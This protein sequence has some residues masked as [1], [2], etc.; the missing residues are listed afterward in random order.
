MG[1]FS[2]CLSLSLQT[3]ALHS[4]LIRILVKDTIVRH[5]NLETNPLKRQTRRKRQ[6]DKQTRQSDLEWSVP[7]REI[8]QRIP[9]L[10]FL[11]L[12]YCAPI[13]PQNPYR[14]THVHFCAKRLPLLPRRFPPVK[15][16]INFQ[17]SKLKNLFKLFGVNYFLFGP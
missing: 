12:K 9:S 13:G 6:Q 5:N 3:F 11:D 10:D 16:K 4:I 8:T 2:K 7:R 14:K 17:K 15:S 1:Y